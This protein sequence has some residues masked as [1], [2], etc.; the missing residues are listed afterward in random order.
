MFYDIILCGVTPKLFRMWKPCGLLNVGWNMLYLSLKH[1]KERKCNL[2]SHSEFFILFEITDNSGWY[3][4]V[5]SWRIDCI[6]VT[7]Q[8]LKFIGFISIF[9]INWL[10]ESYLVNKYQRRKNFARFRRFL[11]NNSLYLSWT[12]TYDPTNLE[13]IIL[14]FD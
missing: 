10:S 11:R 12:W 4:K 7:R 2:R 14:R 5:R 13:T 6:F 1:V 8:V 3:S 9:P